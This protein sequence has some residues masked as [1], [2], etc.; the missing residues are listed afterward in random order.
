[1]I[2]SILKLLEKQFYEFHANDGLQYIRQDFTNF[3]FLGNLFIF[4]IV[5][6]W[7]CSHSSYKFRYVGYLLIYNMITDYLT[8]RLNFIYFTI[9][10]T[11]IYAYY[12]VNY[13]SRQTLKEK[14]K[15]EKQ[16]YVETTQ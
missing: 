15:L 9:F 13:E 10:I 11:G 5:A 12:I 7:L 14:T 4:I 16:L 3:W 8:D 2:S 1:M 6:Y